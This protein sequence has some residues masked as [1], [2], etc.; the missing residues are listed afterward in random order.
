MEL[1][2]TYTGRPVGHAL[3][4]AEAEDRTEDSPVLVSSGVWHV[5]DPERLRASQEATS[6]LRFPPGVCLPGRV[7]RDG[8][9]AGAPDIAIEANSPREAAAAAAGLL[10]G[11]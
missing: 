4:F 7:L 11:M 5:D 8:R 2:C 6:R 3:F 9:P 1:V 10:H